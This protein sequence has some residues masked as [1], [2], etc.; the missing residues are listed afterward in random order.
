MPSKTKPDTKSRKISQQRI[1]H[2]RTLAHKLKP[3]IMLGKAGFSENVLAELELA[4]SHHELV[5]IKL[6]A[7]DRASQDVLIK[8]IIQQTKSDLVQNI[9]HVLVI[10]RPSEKQVIKFD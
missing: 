7:P 10:Y 5:K 8:Q 3:V 4:L 6:S 9:G 1:R 2:L